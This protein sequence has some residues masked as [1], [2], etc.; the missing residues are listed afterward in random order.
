MN[1]RRLRHFLVLAEEKNFHRA[2]TRLYLSQPALSQ[3]LKALE[4]ELGVQLVERRPFRLTPAGE[5]LWAE[6]QRLL[7]AAEALKERV[8]RAGQGVLRFG[9]PENLLPDLMPLLDAL[10]RGLGQALEIRELHTP[11]QVRA[12]KAGVLDYGLA[13]LRVDDPGIAREPLFTIPMVVALPE[14]HPLAREEAVSLAALKEEGFLLFSRERLPPLH[15]AYMAVF[16]QAGFAPRVVREVERFAEAVSLVAAGLGVHLTLAPYRIYPHPGV[17]LRPLAEGMGLE[18]ALIYRKDPPPPR[19]AEV[20]KGLRAYAESPW[21]S[22]SD[23]ASSI[24]P[25]SSSTGT[26]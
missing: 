13:G 15:E 4:E 25:I 18:V 11:D 23:Q 17:V 19:L 22:P 14:D 21:P 6:G 5:V 26:P 8:R 20:L 7:E 16:R 1:I 10:R 12:L 3:S 9:V 24:S 2:A